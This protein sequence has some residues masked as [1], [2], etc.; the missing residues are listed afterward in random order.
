MLLDIC[1]RVSSVIITGRPD[2]DEAINKVKNKI[3]NTFCPKYSSYFIS[4]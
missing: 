3:E 4:P 1:R 2:V